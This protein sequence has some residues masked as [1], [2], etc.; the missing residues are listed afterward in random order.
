MNIISYDNLENILSYLYVSDYKYVNKY[1]YL[2]SRE[3]AS[4]IIKKYIRRFSA[5]CNYIKKKINELESIEH[6]SNE[7]Y[8]KIIKYIRLDIKKLWGVIE[9]TNNITIKNIMYSAALNL[10]RNINHSI[11]RNNIRIQNE[12]SR[13]YILNSELAE[14][15][16]KL[17]D[18]SLYILRNENEYLM[19]IQLK[20]INYFYK[21]F[22]N[23][24]KS[25]VYLE[26]KIKKVVVESIPI[27]W[28]ELKYLTPFDDNMYKFVI[29]Y[30]INKNLKKLHDIYLNKLYDIYKKNGF[31]DLVDCVEID[32]EE[33]VYILEHVYTTMH[34]DMM[35]L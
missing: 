13:K 29:Y 2:K 12:F 21:D 24:P 15:E 34:N 16:S 5:E 35:D 9:R 14:V 25:I 22:L 10:Y 23:I 4:D 32:S 27:K 28:K 26:N 30:I 1:L 11:E 3:N 8:D 20:F 7:D 31:N 17:I 19:K 18:L 6:K 33:Y